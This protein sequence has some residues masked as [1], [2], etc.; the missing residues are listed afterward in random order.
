MVGYLP[1]ETVNRTFGKAPAAAQ[2]EGVPVGH[3]GSGTGANTGMVG[4]GANSGYA[5][6]AGMSNNLSGTVTPEQSAAIPTKQGG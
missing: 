6:G 5:Q 1:E 2:T 4:A 3:P